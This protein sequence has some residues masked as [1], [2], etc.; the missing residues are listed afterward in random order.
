METGK[1]TLIHVSDAYNTA[2]HESSKFTPFE[3]M[4]SRKAILPIDIQCDGEGVLPES[5]EKTQGII[6]FYRHALM[7]ARS[8]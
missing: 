5:L 1:T 3:L 8:R 2:R 4:F 6:V 7:H